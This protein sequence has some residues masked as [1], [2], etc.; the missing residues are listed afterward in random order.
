LSNSILYLGIDFGTTNSSLAWVRDTPLQRQ[1]PYVLREPVKF[2]RTDLG[3]SSGAF[4]V[5]TPTLVG[6]S[7]RGV[8]STLLLG[9]DWLASLV[10]RKKARGTEWGSPRHGTEFFRSVKSDLGSYKVYAYS[11]N[12]ALRTPRDVAAAAIGDLLEKAKAGPLADDELS[13]ARVAIGVPA[14]LSASGR[15]DTLEAAYLAGLRPG[16]V[17]LV[18]EPIA[19]VTDWLNHPSSA[20][21]LGGPGERR[22]LVFDYGGGTLD[23]ALVRV[24]L[25]AERRPSLIVTTLAVS[26]YARR[27]ADAIDTAIMERIVWPQIERHSG[28]LRAQIDPAEQRSI[29][30]LLIPSLVRNL[31]E[32]L[33]DQV[34]QRLVP[35]RRDLAAQT[36]MLRS[37]EVGD[38][39]VQVASLNLKA[40]GVTTPMPRSFSLTAREL[41][42]LTSPMLAEDTDGEDWHVSSL[43]MPIRETL[44]AAG[45]SPAQLDVVLVHGGGCR[46]PFV[47]HG[48][49][50][51]LARQRGGTPG[52]VVRETP[53]LEASVALGAAVAC[54][55][56]HALGRELVAPVTSAAVGVSTLNDKPVEV[57]PRFAPIPFPAGGEYHEVPTEF[58]I[59]LTNQPRLVVPFYARDSA[60]IVESVTLD[61]LEGV[62]AGDVI[63]LRVRVDHSKVLHW[64]Y[65]LEDGAWTSAR[66]VAEAWSPLPMTRAERGLAA[67]RRAMLEQLE[68]SG[69]VSREGLR[70]ELWH[71]FWANREAELDAA[72]TDY[73]ER[74][75]LTG[76]VARLRGYRCSDQGRWEESI[77]WHERALQMEPTNGYHPAAIG[78]ALVQLGRFDEAEARC[79]QALTLDPGLSFIHELL[80]AIRRGK[81]DEARARE[82]LTQGLRVVDVALARAPRDRSLLCTRQRILHALGD[83]GGAS[84]TAS[85]VRRLDEAS[86]LG[87]EPD[88]RIAG[89]D[90]GFLEAGAGRA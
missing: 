87:A 38:I 77:G 59:R 48:L 26:Q 81:G 40:C 34:A 14:G 4:S 49:E 23:L 71:L 32:R 65:R 52:C 85:D 39:K 30:D 58:Y 28:L 61:L 17:E 2:E 83:Y 82:E 72:M 55:Q 79:R 9:W 43:L 18:D 13:Q 56:R 24:S 33:C 3:A 76:N 37:E 86:R 46:N 50:A 64:Q 25:V 67:H 36:A 27:G 10:S 84:E 21:S 57:V 66:A 12:E 47:R 63:R 60:R 16:R 5:R 31:K 88:Y 7:P 68:W 70:M 53:S 90:S 11:N 1:S 45:V 35:L 29:E 15:T 54:Y 78:Q 8:G 89:P 44:D 22:V 80:A 19:A 73:T 69:S 74:F 75:G 42:S 51:W 41:A 6:L 62:K 20:D